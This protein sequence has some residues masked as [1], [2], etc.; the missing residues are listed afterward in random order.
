MDLVV[1]GLWFGG[2]QPAARNLSR[3]AN[4]CSR[5]T[6]TVQRGREETG[7]DSGD[8]L[9]MTLG[10]DLAR[11]KGD[12]RVQRGERGDGS[13]CE[14]DLGPTRICTA[15]RGPLGR[16]KEIHF[17]LKESRSQNRSPARVVGG[18]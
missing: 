8:D 15:S 6:G 4:V 10:M 12:A 17:E 14:D 18:C 3:M 7:R 11:R 9:F 13:E 5:G 2:R 1:F 16:S